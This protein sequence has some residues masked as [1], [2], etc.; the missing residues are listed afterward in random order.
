MSEATEFDTFSYSTNLN[1]EEIHNDEVYNE[2]YCGC[3]ACG[4]SPCCH[5]W[6]C[7]KFTCKYGDSYIEE[8]KNDQKTM[9][10]WYDALRKLGFDEP[11]DLTEEKVESLPQYK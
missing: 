2:T 9:S 4:V 7:R 5:A 11:W 1:L 10:I 3:R 8:H 6:Q